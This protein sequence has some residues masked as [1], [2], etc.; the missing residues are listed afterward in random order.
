[1]ASLKYKFTQKELKKV[2]KAFI[3]KIEA[4]QDKMTI[5][6]DMFC[7]LGKECC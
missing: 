4:E 6:G 2:E 1:M 3:A 5:N 7:P